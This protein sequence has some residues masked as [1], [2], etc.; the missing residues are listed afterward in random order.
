MLDRVVV[1]FW[2]QRIIT[3]MIRQSVRRNSLHIKA[4]RTR[5][6][7]QTVSQRGRRASDLP[8]SRSAGEESGVR[9]DC[10]SQRQKTHLCSNVLSTP[11]LVGE[12][13]WGELT[14]EGFW[15]GPCVPSPVSG[16]WTPKYPLL[17]L[18]EKGVEGMRTKAHRNKEHRE[19]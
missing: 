15:A 14:G 10:P 18:W 7:P 3:G 17:P 13:G 6:L 9:T 11:K 19:R 16:I 5:C 8:L 4:G 2:Q 1:S 12:G